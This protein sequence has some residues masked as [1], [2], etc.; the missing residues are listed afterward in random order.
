[1]KTDKIEFIQALRG[2]AALVVVLYHGMGYFPNGYTV[3]SL[4]YTLLM[5]GGSMG[6]DLFFIISGFIMVHTTWNVRGTLGDVGTFF[7][8]RAAR[9]VPVYIVLTILAVLVM[10]GP[11]YFTTHE[12]W[13]SLAKAFTFQP[14]GKASETPYYGDAPLPIG[15]TLNYEMYFY[16][17]FGACMLFGPRL[18]W[19]ALG[20]IAILTLIVYPQLKRGTFSTNVYGVYNFEPFYVNMITNPIIWLFMAGVA[21]GIIYRAPFSIRGRADKVL[22]R[23]LAMTSVAFAIW[24]YLSE[25]QVNHGIFLWGISLVPLVLC[26]AMCDKAEAIKMPRL[27]VYLGEISFSLYLVHLPVRDGLATLLRDSQGGPAHSPGSFMFLVVVIA[28]EIAMLS[29][30]YLEKK[31]SKMVL[32][33]LVPMR[34]KGELT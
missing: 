8:K 23:A 5:P 11:S 2:I 28:I 13:I 27:L 34:R 22:F 18:R 6:V 33:I 3:G 32:S 29:H 10:H 30:H 17:I 1:V 26:L 20:G 19:I 14:Q 31:L 12:N 21:I 15:W 24:Q 7:A 9:I 4:P 25:F 16:V